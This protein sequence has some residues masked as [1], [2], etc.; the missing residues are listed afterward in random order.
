MPLFFSEFL[1]FC[2]MDKAS[3]QR[4]K[5]PRPDRALVE[6]KKRGIETLQRCCAER[7]SASS[8]RMFF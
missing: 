4:A 6:V 8:S 2:H 1:I 3:V 7:R 5:R